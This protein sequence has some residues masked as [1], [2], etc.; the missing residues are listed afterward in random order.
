MLTRATDDPVTPLLADVLYA[1]PDYMVSAVQTAVFPNDPSYSSMWHLPRISLPTAWSITKGST[2]VGGMQP[3]SVPSFRSA[4][5]VG[6]SLVYPHPPH[7]R[8]GEQ[9]SKGSKAA[10]LAAGPVV[11]PAGA[12]K[13]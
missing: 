3:D 11:H 2:Q 4:K 8:E 9:G 10:A 5:G 7:P 1:E 6:G 12:G 13:G